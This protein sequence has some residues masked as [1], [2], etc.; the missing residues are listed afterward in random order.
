MQTYGYWVGPSLNKSWVKDIWDNW[1]NLN[2]DQVLND[3]KELLVS[4]G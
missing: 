1:G 4:I 3:K 2:V